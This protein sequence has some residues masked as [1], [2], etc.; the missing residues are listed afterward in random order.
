M[1]D[2]DDKWW[3]HQFSVSKHSELF[4]NLRKYFS[5]GNIFNLSRTKGTTSALTVF[6][7]AFTISLTWP[8]WKTERPP[9]TFPR[10]QPVFLHKLRS[11]KQAL[12]GR[13]KW[14]C[15]STTSSRNFSSGLVERAKR[16]RAWKS[17]HARNHYSQEHK[18]K[19]KI[20]QLPITI[21]GTWVFSKWH[22]LQLY[23]RKILV[24]I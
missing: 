24:A 1:A 4:S 6:C 8:Q 11:L 23:F 3:R 21:R 17:P 14:G 10:P 22:V 7:L 19:N 5:I 18:I 2:H 20:F 9:L 16:E 15:L 12:S 13:G